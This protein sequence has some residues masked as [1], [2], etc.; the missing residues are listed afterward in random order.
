[1]IPLKFG[2][3][4]AS[5]GQSLAPAT[6]PQG[7]A[8]TGN[9]INAVLEQSE[10]EY[11]LTQ[12]STVPVP[13]INRHFSAPV[14]VTMDPALSFS[15]LATVM[16]H[17]S[18][19]VSR[20]DAAQELLCSAVLEVYRSPTP[21]HAV[22]TSTLPFDLSTVASAVRGVLRSVHV[23]LSTATSPP[24]DA[25]DSF[26]ASLLLTPPPDA[27]ILSYLARSIRAQH[28][29]SAPPHVDPRLAHAALRSARAA[30]ADQ[31]QTELLEV[32]RDCTRSLAYLREAG[33]ANSSTVSA[34]QVTIRG[35]GPRAL[36]N[37]LLQWM[38]MADHSPTLISEAVQLSAKQYD[39]GVA[40]GNMTKQAGALAAIVHAPRAR[41]G[42]DQDRVL[43]DFFTRFSGDALVLDKWF[44]AQALADTPDTLHRVDEL[45][46]NAAF[47]LD[48]PNKV[49]SLIGAFG[50][51][52]AAF[53]RADGAGYAFMANQVRTRL[54]VFRSLN[55]LNPCETSHV[56]RFG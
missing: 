8:Y 22:S 44:R 7:L 30:I 6:L 12:L 19:P 3:L 13:V 36:M 54:C 34:E 37:V 46:R 31:V 26:T 16:A 32:Y 5:K 24:T 52:A 51:N 18:D 25:L 14:T 49:Y 38:I 43:T 27:V 53:H 39:Q 56:C 11:K 17:D 33:K 21:P 55:R 35:R 45:S 4:S 29:S 15:E 48:N 2:L 41:F 42:A 40:Q 47:R 20:W 28:A 1:V 9:D 50:A 10:A 23:P